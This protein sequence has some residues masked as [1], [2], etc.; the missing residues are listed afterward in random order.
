MAER[1]SHSYKCTDKQYAAAIRRA[2]KLKF[3]LSNLI[4]SVVVAFSSGHDVNF[5]ANEE[6]SVTVYLKSAAISKSKPIK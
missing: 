3:P 1:K 2:K 4:E 6:P 5:Q